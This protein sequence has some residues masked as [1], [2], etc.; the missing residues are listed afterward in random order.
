MK[1]TFVPYKDL[2]PEIWSNLINQAH[3]NLNYEPYF[4]EYQILSY[5]LENLSGVVFFGSTPVAIY[6][7]YLE[8]KSNSISS[9][10]LPPI[11]LT[12]SNLDKE[13]SNKLYSD[14]NK[15]FDGLHEYVI[16]NNR[17]ISWIP[18]TQIQNKKE[19]QGE[20]VLELIINLNDSYDN[21]YERLARNHKRTI[22]RSIDMGQTIVQMDSNS[23]KYLISS[24]FLA[25]M[26]QHIMA[27]GRDRR[28]DESYE[29]MEKLI[30]LG[31]SKLFVSMY[32]NEPISYL[33]CDSRRA[34]ARGWSQVTNLN[35]EKNIFP[36]TLLEWSAIK[37]YKAEGKSIYHLG[38]RTQ[39]FTSGK[40][41]GFE[42]FKRRFNPIE[43]S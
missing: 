29:Y 25:Y 35:L 22:K 24:L 6:V 34:F 5:K 43:I 32:K 10:S 27:A 9:Y 3:A 39:S 13:K 20:S 16:S 15:L 7:V 31:I 11:F 30:R 1:Y 12:E 36:R 8:A 23:S 37:A 42:E 19:S 38:S 2:K 17:L 4:I 18:A 33:Y 26:E 21:L 14:I 40:I 28:P 41:L